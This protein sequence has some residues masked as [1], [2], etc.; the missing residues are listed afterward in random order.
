MNEETRERDSLKSYRA[1]LRELNNADSSHCPPAEQLQRYVN[2][3]L[4]RREARVMEDHL[5]T[6]SFCQ[7]ALQRLKSQE[8]KEAKAMETQQDWAE[9]EKG[10][11][12]KFYSSLKSTN[13][14]VSKKEPVPGNWYRPIYSKWQ[15]LRAFFTSPKA[16][17]AAGSLALLLFL[18]LYSAAYLS[19]PAYFKLAEFRQEEPVILRS[20]A[21][22]SPLMEG[23]FS[24]RQK[25][26][27]AS[28]AKLTSYWA[29]HPDNYSAAYYLGL[30]YLLNAK[31]GLPG[32]AYG[33]KK[34][35][36][37]KGIDYLQKALAL[38]EQNNFYKEDCHWYLGKAFLMMGDKT[39]AIQHFTAITAL[40]QS[41]LMRK[42]EAERMI[43]E[44]K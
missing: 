43:L 31:K 10:L 38:S 22:S 8:T 41:N 18:G 26:Y 32:M 28:I 42:R 23:L 34:S 12:E 7:T 13:F 15:D 17:V 30:S 20:Q 3:E 19:R 16:L 40:Q 36:V 35:E 9:I 2:G 5:N 39:R 21:A 6:C 1:L 14:S 24:F 25:N 27:R 29:A 37:R 44:L 4:S 11:D 33:F